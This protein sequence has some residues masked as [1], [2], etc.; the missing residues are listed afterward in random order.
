MS[1]ALFTS[2]QLLLDPCVLRI[3]CLH[4]QIPKSSFLLLQEKGN[5]PLH[6][7]ANAGQLL[8]VELLCVHGADPSLF[9]REGK[10]PLDYAMYILFI[11]IYYFSHLLISLK[12]L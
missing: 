2:L 1:Q 6:I 3:L 11:S 8:Q 12:G 7:A 5:C 9:D 4:P 10:T